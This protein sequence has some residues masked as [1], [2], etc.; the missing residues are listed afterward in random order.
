MR[1]KPAGIAALIGVVAPEVLT[2]AI[3]ASKKLTNLG[4]PHA[5]VGGLAVGLH[6]HPRATKDADYIVGEAAFHSTSQLLVYRDD[7]KDLVERSDVDLIAVPPGHPH[8]ADLLVL[9]VESTIPVLPVE[10]LVLMKLEA[11]RSQDRA[12]V[13]ALLK[14]GASVDDIARYLRREAPGLL[15]AFSELQEER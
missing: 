11:G 10:A 5:L 9:P 12:D 4:V 13:V 6:G 14:A 3:E 1:P 8:I 15:P 7:L 2:D